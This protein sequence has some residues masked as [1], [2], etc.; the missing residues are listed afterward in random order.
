MRLSFRQEYGAK[1]SFLFFFEKEPDMANVDRP[2][3]FVPAGHKN[4]GTIRANE[5]KIAYN[6]AT[7]LYSGDGVILASGLVTVGAA[8]SATID[9]IFAGCQYANDAGE[10]IFSPYWP[11]VALADSTK[12][13]KAFVYT[14]KG[15]L[16]EVQTETGVAMTQAM[17]GVA[18]D[19]IATHSGSALTG[20]SGQEVT[21]GTAGDAQFMIHG[22]VDRP[23]NALGVNAKVLV[24]LNESVLG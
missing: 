16:F 20:R 11:G 13:V 2:F 1:I 9:G 4:G 18:C 8:N 24:S 10:I 12:V 21:P 5:L 7:A 19:L 15:I 14:D 17:I 3:G 22:L 23:D 6:Y